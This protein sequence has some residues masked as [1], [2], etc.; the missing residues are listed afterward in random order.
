M[1][2]LNKKGM[3]PESE[4][5]ITGVDRLANL[6]DSTFV[7]KRDVMWRNLAQESYAATLIISA[8]CVG[9]VRRMF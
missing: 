9:Q 3:H 2:G 6:K 5:K 1:Q 8:V 4:E 7:V